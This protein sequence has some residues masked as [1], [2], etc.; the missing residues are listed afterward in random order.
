MFLS[1]MAHFEA[2]KIYFLAEYKNFVYDWFLFYFKGKTETDYKNLFLK[3]SI[4][5]FIET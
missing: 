4:F 3:S 5:S 2:Y 1:I